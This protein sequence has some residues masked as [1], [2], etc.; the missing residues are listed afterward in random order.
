M[1]EQDAILN[2]FLER[3]RNAEKR[4]EQLRKDI[5]NK[6]L[7]ISL[8]ENKN[9]NNEKEKEKDKD[10]EK[11]NEKYDKIPTDEE[12]KKI[13]ERFLHEL[14]NIRFNSFD[15]EQSI[16]E[17]T[18]QYITTEQHSK[19]YIMGDFTKWE[20]MPM[21]KNKD[22]FSYKVVLLKGFKYYYSF[23]SGDQILLDYNGLYEENPKNLQVQN[24]IELSENNKDSPPFDFENDINILLNAQKNYFLLNLNQDDEEISFLEKFKRHITASKEIS[25]AKNDEYYR[26]TDSVYNYYDQQN[27]YIKP[28]ESDTKIKNLK[29]YFK[30]RIIAHYTKESKDV[31]Y[32]YLFKIVNIK[33]N[34]CFECLKLYDNNNIKINMNYYND[35]RYYY[36]IFLEKIT[37]KPLNDNSELYQL[38]S[39]EESK[40]KLTDYNNDNDNI[41]KAYFKTLTNLKMDNQNQTQNQNPNFLGGIRTY[42][43]QYGAILVV[44]DRVEPANIDMKDYE[45]Q[46][47]LNKI[48]KVR[49]KKEGSYINYIAIDEAL[50]KAKKPFRFKIYYSIKNNKVNIIHCHVLDKDLR[51]IKMIIKE[52]D[53]NTDPHTLKR[54]EEYIKNNQLLLLVRELT[55]LKLYY[56]GKKVKMESILIEEDKLYLLQSSN[57]DSIFN[58]MYV[59]VNKIEDK[60][61]N[62]LVEQCNEFSYSF[63]DVQN[64][65]DVHVTYDNNK[66][67]VTEPM[68]LAVSPCLL[69]KLSTYEVN[70]LKKNYELKAKEKNIDKDKDKDKDKNI[71]KDKDK[72]ITEM[73]KYFLISQKMNDYRKYN[74]D[75]IAK[76]DQ[77]EKD[78]I[79][80]NLNE[81][82]ESMVIILNFFETSEMWDLMEE[83]AN[84]SAEIEEL[85][86]LF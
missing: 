37:N 29:L 54:T 66:N 26:L 14:K 31:K 65:I 60:L 15:I 73:D 20:L 24:F 67:Y 49:N 30:D 19:L 9:E 76:L 40:K 78:N 56:K 45:F 58:K 5:E 74:K 42:I 1:E 70:N 71:D 61:V 3:I 32:K 12:D 62:S 34:N 43:R 23:Q 52:I 86:K 25:K 18:I 2:E 82:K 48:T 55:P 27:K 77:K 11:D 57:V 63:D 22:I 59:T 51:S 72:N 4:N 41:L 36:N 83:G 13:S 28:Y 35:I 79:K 33:D 6:K 46:Y 38:L 8:Y 7:E 50:E 16:K 75:S 69:Q 84:L 80:S 39:I 68:T 81:Y 21:K 44:P 85:I 10:K 64:G 17:I 53:K 47:S